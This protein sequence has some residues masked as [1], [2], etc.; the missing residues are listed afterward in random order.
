M[1]QHKNMKEDKF[2][3]CFMKIMKRKEKDKGYNMCSEYQKSTSTS[4]LEKK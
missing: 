2:Q 3:C 1:I 4:E